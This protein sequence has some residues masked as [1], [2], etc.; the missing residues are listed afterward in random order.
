MKDAL[1]DVDASIAMVEYYAGWADKI[2][3]KTIPSPENQFTFTKIEP[4]GVCGQIIPWNFPILMF[5][6]KVAPATACGCTVV[7]KPAEQTPVCLYSNIYH[8]PR[9]ISNQSTVYS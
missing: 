4:V 1:G 7:V 2:H 8:Y 3:G 5:V 6:F 9:Q